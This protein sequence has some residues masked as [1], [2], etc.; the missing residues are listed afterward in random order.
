MAVEQIIKVSGREMKMRASALTPR[1]YRAKFGRDLMADMG[2]LQAAAARQAALPDQ[3]SPEQRRNADFS[4][5]E[6][7]VFE[8]VAYIMVKH[9]DDGVPDSPEEW[10]DSIDGVFFIYRILPVIMRMWSLN[11]ATT[12][13]P[14]KKES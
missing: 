5:E 3:A 10:L 14:K 4:A 1:L 2:L 9:A 11:S 12:S 8:N 6:L 7:T 13:I